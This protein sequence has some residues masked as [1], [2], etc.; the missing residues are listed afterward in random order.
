MRPD[1]SSADWAKFLITIRKG[2][3][4]VRILKLVRIG[5]LESAL[6]HPGGETLPQVVFALNNLQIRLPAPADQRASQPRYN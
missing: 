3:E 6:F 2:G 4:F 1:K 5:P